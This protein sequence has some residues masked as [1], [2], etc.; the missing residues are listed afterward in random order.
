MRRNI[1]DI[2]FKAWD[3]ALSVDN[4]PETKK[5]CYEQ[6][7]EFVEESAMFSLGEKLMFALGRANGSAY[8]FW[9]CS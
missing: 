6:I 5:M 2:F 3:D 1:R 4:D 7:R 8:A 9:V